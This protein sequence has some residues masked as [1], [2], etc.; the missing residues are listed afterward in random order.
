MRGNDVRKKSTLF[1]GGRRQFLRTGLVVIAGSVLATR[2][3]QAQSVTE[4]QDWNDLDAIRNDLSGG[5]RLVNDLDKTTAGY[6]SH[7][8]SSPKGWDPIGERD[9]EDEIREP[10]NGTFDGNGFEISGLT[11]N[12]PETDR[13]GLFSSLDEGT[14]TDVSVT[15]VEVTGEGWVGGVVG[16]INPGVVSGVKVTG[17]VD[18]DSFVGGIA[19]GNFGELVDSTANCDVSGNADIGGLVGP[20]TGGVSN[21]YYNVL[22]TTINGQQQLTIGGLFAEQYQDWQTNGR[23]LSFADY[24]SL[25]VESGTVELNDRQGVRD[26]LGFVDDPDL[27]WRLGADIDLTRQSVDLYLPYLA[28]ELHG[29]GHSLVIDIDLPNLS[30]IGAVGYNDGM[31]TLVSVNGTVS[32][33]SQ[34]G[35]LVGEN[36]GV[37]S[38]S[39]VNVDVT[40]DS[41]VGGLIGENHDDV[42][43][44]EANGTVTGDL[45][46]GGL[47]GMNT[48]FEGTVSEIVATGNVTGGYAVGGLIG[49]NQ[50]GDIE[51]AKASGEV[52]GD[53][54]IGGIVGEGGVDGVM[55][56]SIACG[57]VSGDRGVGGII[58]ARLVLEVTDCYWDKEAAEG[59][60]T[61]GSGVTGLETEEMQGEAAVEN[62]P[63]LDFEDTWEAVTTPPDYPIL[64]WQTTTEFESAPTTSADDDG[65]GFGVGSALAGAG[66]VGYLLKKGYE[67]KTDRSD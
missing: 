8:A 19:G 47:I 5:Y 21:S 64:Q 49:Q 18:G 1:S 12:R 37:V 44:A 29:N 46:V 32:A 53:R 48:S 52:S 3:G 39:K 38:E 31:I 45:N 13:V 60:V 26:A 24:N 16:V 23:D 41:S 54:Y 4:I 33:D 50:T 63:P 57:P 15:D 40:G 51:D 2:A 11:I 17:R 62:M 59:D 20:H 10:F 42:S 6:E 30:K 56:N 25:T 28:G 9:E 55:Q 35:G 66:G 22:E 67:H 14:I 36:H 34:V 7:V 61:D 43:K 65:P 27:N 58:G